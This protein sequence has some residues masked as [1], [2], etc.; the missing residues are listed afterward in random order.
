ME[1][2]QLQKLKYPIGKFVAPDAIDKNL[3]ASC[4]ADIAAF[5][6]R[7]KN[8][9]EHLSTLQLDTP[10]RPGGWTIRQ[11]VHHCADSHMNSWMRF[12][13]ALTEDQ[14]VIKPYHEDRWA[15]LPDSKIMDIEPALLLIQGLHSKWEYLLQT[16]SSA[17]LQR[18]FV[19]PEHGKE[20]KLDVVITLYA[21]HCNHHL[22]HITSLISRQGW[23]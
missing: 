16:L 6:Q 7:L 20:Y 9:V 1:D 3:I 23:K 13:L 8:A 21:W 4:I 18:I 5:P 12:K 22:A 2:Q 15:E 14:P 19:H 17:D 10:Y 11:V